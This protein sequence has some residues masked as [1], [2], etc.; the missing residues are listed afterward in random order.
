MYIFIDLLLL[1]YII[2]NINSRTSKRVREKIEQE[3]R[4][5]EEKDI[6]FNFKK[7]VEFILPD[8]YNYEMGGKITNESTNETDIPP[9][10]PS[11]YLD[12][13]LKSLESNI[14]Y[15]LLGIKLKYVIVI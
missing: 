6:Y 5:T 4:L 12:E 1:F 2:Y 14:E 10:S 7:K 15:K 8:K 3:T 11:V 9:S 13:N